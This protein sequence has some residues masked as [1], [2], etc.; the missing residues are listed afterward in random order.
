MDWAAWWEVPCRWPSRFPMNTITALRMTLA[1]GPD[2]A[3]LA[4]A[5][6][7]AYWVEDR[8]IND[9]TSCGPSPAPQA[10]TARPCSSG[11]RIRPSRRN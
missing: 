11:P 5:L 10:A 6:F 1:A 8:D 4:H 7:A 3:R 9:K 2:M